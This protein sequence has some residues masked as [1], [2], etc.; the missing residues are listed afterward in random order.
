MPISRTWRTVVD[1]LSFP[2][3]PRWRDGRLWFSD[4]HG[5][6]IFRTTP[7]HAIERVATL[8]DRVGGLGFLPDGSVLAVSMLDRRLI[9]IDSS[10]RTRVHADLSAHCSGFIND[11]VVD[12]AGRAYVGGRNGESPERRSDVLIRVE[13]DGFA[14]IEVADMASP[15]GAVILPGGEALVVAET[16][17]GRLLRFS[18]RGDGRLADRAIV[19]ERDGIHIDGIALDADGGI[20]A[21]GGVHGLLR[22]SRAFELVEVVDTPGRMVLATALGGA[23]GRTLFL[24]TVSR[25]LLANLAYVGSDR[26]RDAAV[27]SDGRIEAVDVGE[28]VEADGPL[29]GSAS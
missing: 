11:M 12:G 17:H 21:G 15:N 20:W 29:T 3:S 22:I 28:G 16:A 5:H 27:R 25:S 13:P 10:G 24:A 26:R 23:D 8:P 6:G 9:A 19:F 18:I 2:E 7:T 1:G 4:I 14:A